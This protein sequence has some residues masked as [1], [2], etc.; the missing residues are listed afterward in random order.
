L[1]ANESC[2][3]GAEALERRNLP[4]AE[5]LLEQCLRLQPEEILPYLQLCAIYQMQGKAEALY[6]VALEGL[7]R[8]PQEKRFYLTVGTQ[9]GR[10]KRY[11]HAVEVL[12][13]GFRRWPQ[14]DQLRQILE[15]AHL[16][17]GMELLDAGKNESAETNLRRATRL[18]AD[19]IEA[20]LNLGR[21][22]H[23]LNQTAEALQE[24]DRVL[25]LN[26]RLPLAR[27]HRGL[28]LYTIGE[29]DRAIAD[30]S[31]EMKANPDYPPSYL[32]RG[33]AFLAKGEWTRAL[34]DLETAA[35]RMPE[36]AK[37]QYARALCLSRV[38]EPSNAEAGFRRTIELDPSD[39]A[40]LNS[41][42]RLLLQ[43]GREEEAVPLIRRSAELSRQQRSTQP[44]EIRFDDLRPAKSR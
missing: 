30:F 6:R 1:K 35:T 28:T 24:F 11:E 18:A 40:P 44:G 43:S 8:F 19:D 31:A 36:N 22:L 10:D 3:A 42:A 13:A 23:N 27:F 41:L 37:A 15:S 33:S 29:F 38:G 39:P 16:G 9:D 32:L 14:D 20:H 2:R 17:L 21:A 4:T 12:E 25:A 7:K 34:R 26:P 5:A